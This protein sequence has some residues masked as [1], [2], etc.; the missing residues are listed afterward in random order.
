MTMAPQ[1]A[2]RIGRGAA[3]QRPAQTA[4]EKAYFV[5]GTYYP[6]RDDDQARE[7]LAALA[8]MGKIK[9]GDQD[10]I[11][12]DYKK[13]QL[14]E[15]GQRA[16]LTRLGS[17]VEQRQA[18]GQAEQIG[19][20]AQE[21]AD[22]AGQ[23]ADLAKYESH[24][25]AQARD[26]YESHQQT[27]AEFEARRDEADQRVREYRIG[28]RRD[29]GVRIVHGLAAALGALGAGL[30]KTPNFALQSIEASLDRDLKSQQ[31]EFS[32][33]KGQGKEARSDLAALYATYGENEKA[34]GAFRAMYYRETGARAKASMLHTSNKRALAALQQIVDTSAIKEEM[35]EKGIA[36]TMRAEYDQMLA[37]RRQAQ[38]QAVKP[39]WISGQKQD[40]TKRWVS[41]GGGR[42]G[43]A[44][45]AEQARNLR[46]ALSTHKELT[47]VNRE[48]SRI[49][50]MPAESLDNKLRQRAKGLRARQVL[51]GKEAVKLGVLAGP[52]MDI[53]DDYLGPEAAAVG[54]MDSTVTAGIETFQQT[55][56][57]GLKTQMQGADLAPASRQLSREGPQY[58]Y[59]SG[60]AEPSADIDEG[61]PVK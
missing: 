13:W 3:P 17:D 25:Q 34:H 28:D 2:T 26:R 47:Q 40:L 44:A 10:R 31:E 36:Y 33:L 49:N 19:L 35:A 52:D 1:V 24:E 55:L 56:D 37:L 11:F 6:W 21:K 57:L 18:E 43:I 20:I 59:E 38:A 58:R 9:E 15:K 29:A 39:E 53:M 22:A 27:V 60:T 41:L 23:A 5:E 48:L 61:A 45:D 51:V 30:A 8:T 16:G 42:G 14:T 46:L 7:E 4:Y 54:N 50:Q 32:A 12:K